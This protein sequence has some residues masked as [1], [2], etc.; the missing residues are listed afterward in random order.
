MNTT[1]N[2]RSALSQN[3]MLRSTVVP[4]VFADGA[5]LLDLRTKFFYQLN[6]SA[7]AIVQL[8]ETTGID[9][10][11]VLARTHDWGCRGD[12][13]EEV[14]DFLKR[15]FEFDLLEEAEAETPPEIAAPATW[16]SPRIDRQAEPLH[17]LVTSAF[18]PSIPLAE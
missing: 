3:S 2:Q 16:T 12:A 13:V 18:D 10:S 1:S 11:T 15:L 17:R 4:T 6:G 9:S 5:V 7:W 14:R 8:L